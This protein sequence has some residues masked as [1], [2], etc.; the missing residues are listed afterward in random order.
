MQSQP[1]TGAGGRS[2]LSSGEG[3][4]DAAGMPADLAAIANNPQFA[5]L[6]QMVQENPALIQPMIQ[7]LAA[8]NPGLAQALADNPEILYQLLGGEGMEGL[9]EGDEWEGGDDPMA[10]FGEGGAHNTTIAVTAEEN[11]AIQRVRPC[12]SSPRPARDT[13][14]PHLVSFLR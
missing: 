11:E 5:Q 1:G 14:D 13:A 12:L 2:A 10:A 3:A 9:E 4:G 6:R 7:Q 8:S